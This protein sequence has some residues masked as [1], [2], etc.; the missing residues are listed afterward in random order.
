MEDLLS[1]EMRAEWIEKT[2]PAT[3]EELKEAGK[4]YVKPELL[5]AAFGKHSF[6]LT[7]R[8]NNMPNPELIAL[9]DSDGTLFDYDT[10]MLQ[11]LQNL[12][13]PGEKLLA[14]VPRGDDV[15]SYLRARMNLISASKEW[16]SK[17]PPLDFGFNVLHACEQMGFR[18]IILTQGP[19]RNPEA[20][21]GKKMLIDKHL[22]K[23][24]D[25]TITRD[26][27]LVYGKVLVDDYPPYIEA[28]LKWRPRG[29]VIMPGNESNKDFTHPQ[30]IRY[31]RD[32][33]W[34]TVLGALSA[35][36]ADF[37]KAGATTE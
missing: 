37:N 33:D 24:F 28:W 23:D 16:W 1:P 8:R 9:F 29:L 6:P 10:A 35:I 34:P 19:K 17:I 36:V 3:R 11:R 2:R 14:A 22:G 21:A 31:A 30:V 25:I 26:K 18:C 32:I 7:K 12:Q 4:Q 15:P 13:S 20:W 5:E 27:S